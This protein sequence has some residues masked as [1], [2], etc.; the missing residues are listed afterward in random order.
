METTAHTDRIDVDTI[1]TAEKRHENE[2]KFNPA[3]HDDQCFICG[4]GMTA[5]GVANGASVQVSEGDELIPAGERPAD[6]IGFY[7]VGSDCA[8]KVPAEFRA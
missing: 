5:Q 2:A 1:V 3:K 6:S 8:R 7:P 4:K